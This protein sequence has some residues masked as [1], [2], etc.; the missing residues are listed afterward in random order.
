MNEKTAF[1]MGIKGFIHKP[2]VPSAM[3]DIIREV[4]D[5][6]CGKKQ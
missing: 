6:Y 3:S 1:A 4:L 5:N 2:V